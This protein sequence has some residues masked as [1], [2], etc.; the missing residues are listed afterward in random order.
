MQEEKA[1]LAVLEQ[2]NETFASKGLDMM[3][4]DPMDDYYASGYTFYTD[5]KDD[6]FRTSFL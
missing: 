5:P 2:L 6:L 4:D 3:Y 1:A